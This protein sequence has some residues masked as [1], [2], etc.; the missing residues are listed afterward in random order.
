MENQKKWRDGDGRIGQQIERNGGR[1]A[2]IIKDHG[3]IEDH[4]WQG[5]LVFAHGYRQQP[6]RGAVFATLSPTIAPPP[7]ETN[8]TKYHKNGRLAASRGIRGEGKRACCTRGSGT[9]S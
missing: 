1:T 3:V 8:S 7:V 9:N 4:K 6:F 2:A 5:Q